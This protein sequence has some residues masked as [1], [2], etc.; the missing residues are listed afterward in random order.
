MYSKMCTWCHQYGQFATSAT[1]NE[2]TKY[3]ARKYPCGQKTCGVIW[4]AIRLLIIF[5]SL[6]KWA[7]M[8]VD[9]I[10]AYTQASIEMAVYMEMLVLRVICFELADN[11]LWSKSTGWV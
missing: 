8:H 3:K 5:A 2:I 9:F 4:F 7:L 6:F 1:I 10:M 11:S